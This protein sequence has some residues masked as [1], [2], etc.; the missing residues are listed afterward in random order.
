MEA[1]R[2]QNM[3]LYYNQT[4]TDLSKANGVQASILCDIVDLNSALLL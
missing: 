2:R 3:M 1:W 4:Q